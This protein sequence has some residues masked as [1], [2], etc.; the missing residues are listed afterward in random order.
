MSNKNLQHSSVGNIVQP[1]IGVDSLFTSAGGQFRSMPFNEKIRTL[2]P[3][4][5]AA[6]SGTIDF[7]INPESSMVGALTLVT[8]VSALVG[9]TDPSPHFDDYLGIALI[10]RIQI[11]HGSDIV[12][13]YEQGSFIVNNE[14]GKHWDEREDAMMLG[15]LSQA[16]R[17]GA[18][19][20]QQEVRLSIPAF[21]HSQMHLPVHLL[22]KELILRVE[23]ES[24]NNCAKYLLAGVPTAIAATTGTIVSARLEYEQIQLTQPEMAA[25]AQMVSLRDEATNFIG[26]TKKNVGYAYH[27]RI[28]VGAADTVTSVR[29]D[30]KGAFRS[31]FFMYR[32]AA[33]TVPPRNIM[34]FQQWTS[35][36]IT[37]HG[38]NIVEPR[39]FNAAM[40]QYN[41]KN[42]RMSAKEA[43]PAIGFQTWSKLPF[44]Y[45]ES[46]GLLGTQSMNDLTLEIT[47]PA[48]GAAAQFDVVVVYESHYNINQS[49]NIVTPAAI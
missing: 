8:T 40:T 37:G 32:L 26:Y 21:E 17:V 38:E 28:V 2:T 34:N 42:S 31:V 24:L 14:F 33:D 18:A 13:T 6:Y 43:F 5:A 1:H 9:G 10:R 7:Q 39:T 20:A 15:S 29:L 11:L 48:P 23:Y 35:F 19:A 16:Q 25:Q 44:D 22:N 46:A 41:V 30:R 27:D 49:G 47:H 4:Q 45:H 36:R 3:Q 12:T